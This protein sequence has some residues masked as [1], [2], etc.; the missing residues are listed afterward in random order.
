[1]PIDN[2]SPDSEMESST[3]AEGGEETTDK[4]TEEEDGYS[5]ALVPKAFFKQEMK[6]GDTETIKVLKVY[7]GDYEV[8]CAGYDN[9]ESGNES[10]GPPASAMDESMSSMDKLAM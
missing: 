8:E 6:P 7:E 2:Y 10:S 9:K 4:S 3:P 1:M 5:T